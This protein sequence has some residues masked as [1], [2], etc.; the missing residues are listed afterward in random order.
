MK[1][2]HAFSAPLMM[3]L[4]LTA[5][6]AAGQGFSPEEAVKRM[7]VP[8]GFTVK[9]AACEP[10]IR[11]PVSISFDDRGRMWV[12]QYLQY[13]NPAGLKAVKVD[14]YL[15]TVYDKLPEPP[16][17]GPKGA[18][19]I[20]ILEDK[21]GDGRY[22]KVRDF[23]TGL[24][25]A[26]G[27]CIGH[28]GV[29]VVQPP[30]LLFYP[31]R[32]GDAVPDGDPEVL[33]TGFGMEDAHAFANSLQWGPDG[34]LYGAQGST[35]TANIRGITFQQG[36]W[37]YHPRT[38]E[39]ELFAEGGGNTWGLDFDRHGNA[40]AGT[41]YGNAAMLHQVQGAYYIKNFG[42]HGEL[43][44]PHAYG[45][46]DHVPYK[47][48]K[49]GHVT[50]GGVVYQGGS[51]PKSFDNTYIAANLL[52]NAV[53]WHVMERKGSSLTAHF[54]GDLVIAN[55]TWFR[56]VD[57][58][59]GPDGSVFVADWYDKRAN[60]V[61]P[62]DNWDRTN[63]RVYKIEANGTKPVTGLAL[64]N[65][66]SRELVGLLSHPNSWYHGEARRLLA[67]RRDPAVIPGLRQ[68]VLENR[69]DL[70]LES[71]WALY[72]SGGF[73]DTLAATLLSHANE[74]VRAW[75]VR[76]LGDAKKV[77]PEIQRRLVETAKT[78]ASCVVRN[79]LAC[80]CKRL[81]AKDGLPIVWELLKRSEDLNDPQIPLLLWWAIE[82]KAVSAREMVRCF[83]DVAEAWR[84]PLVRQFI[85]ERLGRRYM[86][87]GTDEGMAACARLLGQSPGMEETDLVIRGMDKAL[88]GRHLAQM[89]AVLEKP[90]TDLCGERPA[91]LVLA[92]LA[93]RLGSRPAYE[94]ALQIVADH[95]A[96]VKDRLSLIEVLGQMGNAACVPTLL[97]LLSE[98]EPVPIRTAALAGLQPFPD[99]RITVMVVA[100]YP[101]MP[102]ALRMRAQTLLLSRAAS[103]LE[104]LHSIEA[105]R[106]A[107]SEVAAEQLRR[108]A[109]HHDAEI[110][111][112]VEKHWGK[113]SPA[114]AGEKLARIGNLGGPVLGRGKGD[115][116]RGKPIF[117]KK[118][119]T[120]HTLFG[121]GAK[122]GPDLTGVDRKDRTFLLTSI[123]D[124]SAVIRKEYLAYVVSTTNGRLLT[125][126]IAEA[127]SKT[128]TLIDA[129]NERTLLS[130][131]EIEDMKPSPQSLMPE[132]L[133]DDLDDRQ[134]RDL[135]SYLQSNGPV[136][137]G[138]SAQAVAA[139]PAKAPLKVC[140]VSGSLEY[141]SDESLSAFQKYLEEQY[142]VQ[143]SRAFRKTDNDLPGLEN[144]ATCDVM[145]LFT[146]RLTISGEQM[147]RVKKYCK[148]GKP[149]VAV[150]TAS[151]AFQN[152]LDLDKEVLGGNYKNHYGAGPITEVAIVEKARGHPILAGVTPFCSPASLYKNPGVGKDV[153]VLLTGTIPGHTEP[154]AWTHLHA[155]GRVF[156]T[157]L[158]HPDDFKEKNFQR[159]LVNALFW[160]SNRTPEK[161]ASK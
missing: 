126:L 41:N 62:I 102:S 39:F 22:H 104:F 72:V 16:P 118:C 44:N 69:G 135:F 66:S 25:L 122:V 48:F 101:K 29:F 49:G 65:L 161:K 9:L 32:N 68:T 141:K 50:C 125:G 94:R 137:S 140:L 88:E 21:N 143:C 67:E 154:I 113:F 7:Q 95:K 151:H 89:P 73:D 47:G 1:R 74:D 33:L 123:V 93:V 84:L 71:L 148:S 13:P 10:E 12:I 85:V 3:L 92:K 136:S 145:F 2:I 132:G 91:N 87:E 64:S 37:R 82:D 127:T 97:G 30:Y 157:S 38:R 11:Q 152:W 75:T 5:C 34:W 6:P 14:R 4:S 107:V 42:K 58:L 130:R 115:A 79:Q 8:E 63:G 119:A 31:D 19:V 55:D 159:L 109:L 128:V 156:Y 131:E 86:A 18:D 111:R 121:E 146:R 54:G 108:M 114:T 80:S 56:P 116:A 61:D 76:L 103:T 51:F 23:V 124:P 150:R 133:L 46:F 43:Q 106:I 60:H 35:V 96:P 120:C 112:L 98:A 144:L 117:E 17:R 90:I 160:V 134:I 153:E 155:A 77:A 70:A 142:N 53:Y 40:I 28:G 26:S 110:D 158:G 139:A 52:S 27:M 45:Y 57:C 78:D 147:E 105:G 100:S 81:P 83:L 59:T 36:I 138:G 24:N 15:R 129:K 149:I 20:T 99:H